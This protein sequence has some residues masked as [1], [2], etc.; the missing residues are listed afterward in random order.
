[1]CAEPQ[2]CYI[3][4]HKYMCCSHDDHV[5]LYQPIFYQSERDH[6]IVSCSFLILFRPKTLTSSG[7]NRVALLSTPRAFWQCLDV[8]VPKHTAF[9]FVYKFQLLQRNIDGLQ[10]NF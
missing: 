7:P 1:M 2:S 4:I 5:E 10:T 6:T 8:A 9:F 3:A